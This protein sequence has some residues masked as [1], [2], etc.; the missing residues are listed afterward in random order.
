VAAQSVPPAAG[1]PFDL[2]FDE[3]FLSQVRLGIVSV[4]LAREQATFPELKALLGVTQGN[5]GMHL[6]RLEETG[7]VA[8]TKDFVGRK[9]RTTARLTRGGRAAFL[10][11]VRRLEDL[12]R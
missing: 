7:Y 4:L 3:A 8:V 10:R 6:Q 12:S 11:H 9:P 1:E 2:P 5:L